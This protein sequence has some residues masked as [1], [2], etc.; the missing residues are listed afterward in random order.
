MNAWCW[1]AGDE[2]STLRELARLYNQDLDDYVAT[3]GER[4]AARFRPG[5]DRGGRSGAAGS[6]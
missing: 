2:R 6:R 1:I 5:A 3:F 4:A